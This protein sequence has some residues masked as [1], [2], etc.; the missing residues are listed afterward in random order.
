M[1]TNLPVLL[2]S[3]KFLKIHGII[4][5]FPQYDTHLAMVRVAL[6][7]VTLKTIYFRVFIGKRKRLKVHILCT[8]SRI[9]MR[10]MMMVVLSLA[11]MC[12]S[13]LGKQSTVT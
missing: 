4:T 9:R 8:A 1:P 6:Q 11:E 7:N 10:Q 3:A 5:Q 13:D 12:Y 2:G